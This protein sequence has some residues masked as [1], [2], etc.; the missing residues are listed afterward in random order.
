MPPIQT[1]IQTRIATLADAEAIAPLFDAYRQF[2]E[3]PANLPLAA[4]FISDRLRNNES[5]ILLAVSQDQQLL[6]FC[7]FY[8][9][10][11]SV[12]AMPVYSLYGLFVL[13][14][15][16]GA[17][18]RARRCC[19]PLKGMPHVTV[20]HDWNSPRQRRTSRPN[21]CMS[22]SVGSGMISSTDTPNALRTRLRA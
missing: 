8:P 5:V 19:R 22:H 15:K 6:G 20:L 1:T 14:L 16:Q 2:Y 3:Q 7:Q 11:C 4:R 21:P 12:E 9:S 18:A 10:F 17:T 13:N